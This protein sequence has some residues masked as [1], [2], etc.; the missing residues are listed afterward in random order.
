MS[1]RPKE[2]KTE[3]GARWYRNVNALGAAACFGIG[4]LVP[5]TAP[6]MNLPGAINAAQAAGGEVVR[7]HAKKNKKK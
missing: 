6:V 4:V 2:S 3:K 5:P 7:R 1:E